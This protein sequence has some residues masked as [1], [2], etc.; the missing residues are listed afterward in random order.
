MKQSYVVSVVTFEKKDAANVVLT[1]RSY[2][3]NM[4]MYAPTVAEKPVAVNVPKNLP[5]DAILIAFIPGRFFKHNTRVS[6]PRGREIARGFVQ[7]K[8]QSH[9][10]LFAWLRPGEE[11]RYTVGGR[12]GASRTFTKGFWRY[13][14]AYLY[15]EVLV[16]EGESGPHG[17][18]RHLVH[19]PVGVRCVIPVDA[20]DAAQLAA[21]EKS[22]KNAE[23]ARTGGDKNRGIE[24]IPDGLEWYLT[25]SLEEAV[26]KRETEMAAKWMAVKER[27]EGLGLKVE[28]RPVF[29]DPDFLLYRYVP[30]LERVE[31]LLELNKKIEAARRD[32]KPPF[33]SDY[34]WERCKS[35]PISPE[36]WDSHSQ[37]IQ[38][39][40]LKQAEERLRLLTVP[41][42]E[43]EL[44]QL[45][46]GKRRVEDIWRRNE[47][48]GRY[49]YLICSKSISGNPDSFHVTSG[50]LPGHKWGEISFGDLEAIQFLE[51]VADREIGREAG[52][53]P[54][55][56]TAAPIVGERASASQIEALHKHFGK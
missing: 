45:A 31:Q 36:E 12:V 53:E 11:I 2:D 23:I 7:D 26:K 15:H 56:K 20:D 55:K 18:G 4:G 28:K 25:F 38:P 33:L 39:W 5:G 32:G 10:S 24:Y 50:V 6:C 22:R 43:E 40:H 48:A 30:L 21:W 3:D 29:N 19:G 34:H 46:E 14:G 51:E 47:A 9:E 17:S 44:A 35:V 42:T 27:I 1:E 52:K 54:Q 13:T 41:P 16:S 8:K 37:G 49:K